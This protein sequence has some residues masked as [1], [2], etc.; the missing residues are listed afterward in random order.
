[1]NQPKLPN[2]Q[3][4]MLNYFPGFNQPDRAV[5]EGTGTLDGFADDKHFAFYCWLGQ[6][7]RILAEE[8]K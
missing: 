1:L 6:E 2:Y 4:A 3:E 7:Q 5:V 8:M